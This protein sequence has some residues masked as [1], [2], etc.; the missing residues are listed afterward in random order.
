MAANV[1]LQPIDARGWRAGL[2]SLVRKELRDW[3]T[4]NTWWRQLLI[5][6]ILLNGVWALVLFTR[7]PEVRQ[8]PGVEIFT[9]LSG[10]FAPLGVIILLG[11][12]IATEKVSGT[13]AWI[14]SKPVSR[15]EFVLSK[16][17]A[18]SLNVLITMIVAPGLVAYLEAAAAELN[19][20][21]SSFVV[22]LGLLS[23][24]LLF[25]VS[26]TVML[27]TFFHS[28]TPVI[29]IAALLLFL[30]VGL[31]EAAGLGPLL[32]GAIPL[33]APSVMLGQPLPALFPVG[34]AAGLIVLFS[35][36]AIVRFGRE[37]F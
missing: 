3:W 36:V 26:L 31:S 5:W 6:L 27:G 33:M 22:G 1:P 13:A 21:A 9:F 11:G 18:H 37:E 15:S 2:A 16:L 25:Y 14:L 32:P 23:L 29:G 28:P 30:Q 34:A 8:G 17:V 7:P 10:I 4:T 19:L 12:T 20:A 35:A 24:N